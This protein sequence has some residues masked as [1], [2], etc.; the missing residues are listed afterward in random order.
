[1]EST[2]VIRWKSKMGPSF[3]QGKKF[4]TREEAEAV[5]DELNEDYPDFIHQAVNVA[6]SSGEVP[7][8]ASEE[9]KVLPPPPPRPG[10]IVEFPLAEALAV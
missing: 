9:T 5:A 10:V 1:M 3:G 7:T 2:Y 6:S 4:F 8:P